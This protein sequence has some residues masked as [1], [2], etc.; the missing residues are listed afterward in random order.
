MHPVRLFLPYTLSLGQSHPALQFSKFHTPPDLS[1][2]TMSPILNSNT[3]LMHVSTKFPV[4]QGQVGG[5]RNRILFKVRFSRLED[6]G[7]N[8][9]EFRLGQVRL[10]VQET[11]ISHFQFSLDLVGG[12]TKQHISFSVRLEVWGYNI[13]HFQLGLARLV[14][15]RN[16]ISNFRNGQARLDVR[17]NNISHFRIGQARLDVRGNNISHFRIGY[18]AGC[19]RK[20][21]ISFSVI[22]SHF[23]LS[24]DRL[25][26]QG[27][28]IR[29][30]YIAH[31]RLGQ[32]R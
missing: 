19:P 20:Q 11:N 6:L 28:N 27:D 26:V 12:P 5:W 32:S 29:G 31:F 7:N 17:G 4:R 1:P 2:Y 25:E 14:V 9:S 13:P 3:L 8:V 10:E 16:N 23:Q 18:Q 15:Q 22:T 21:H 24:L 30:N